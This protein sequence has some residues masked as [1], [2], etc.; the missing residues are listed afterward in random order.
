MVEVN[1]ELSASRKDSGPQ[2]K[3]IWYASWSY[4]IVPLI[5]SCEMSPHVGQITLVV[6]QG[7]Y[8]ERS[9]DTETKSTNHHGVHTTIVERVGWSRSHQ[10]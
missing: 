7:V 9:R 10:R 4:W 5:A 3:M 8:E 1:T 2:E 6:L